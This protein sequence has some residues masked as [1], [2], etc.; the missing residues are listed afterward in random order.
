MMRPLAVVRL[1]PRGHLLYQLYA[2]RRD[3]VGSFGSY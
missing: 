2:M 1:E 3:T